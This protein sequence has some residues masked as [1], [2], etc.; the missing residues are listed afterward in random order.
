[1]HWPIPE[2]TFMVAQINSSP[3]DTNKHTYVHTNTV[4]V[5]MCVYTHT[6]TS[7]LHLHTYTATCIVQTN[8][9]VLHICVTTSACKH[10]CMIVRV[11]LCIYIYISMHVCVCVRTQVAGSHS[12]LF[13]GGNSNIPESNID[14][15]DGVMECVGGLKRIPTDACQ[16]YTVGFIWVFLKSNVLHVTILTR[17]L[18][19]PLLSFVV[20]RPAGAWLEGIWEYTCTTWHDCMVFSVF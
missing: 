18:L 9:V 4:S 20:Q 2:M 17:E 19:T 12:S 13:Q 8:L 10:V 7:F 3:Q 15:P 1:M 14:L 5:C 11:C 6:H 16:L